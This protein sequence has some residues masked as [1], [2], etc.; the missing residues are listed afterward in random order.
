LVWGCTKFDEH[1]DKALRLAVEA[2][3]RL[4]RTP[5]FL[6]NI[7]AAGGT[8]R[9]GIR[10]NPGRFLKLEYIPITRVENRCATGKR[11]ISKRLF[12]VVMLRHSTALGGET[13]G[14]GDG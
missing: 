6:W 14:L 1:W 12:A 2:A 10:P 4:L 7:N 11:C 5:G 9:R 8:G 3:Y 13:Q